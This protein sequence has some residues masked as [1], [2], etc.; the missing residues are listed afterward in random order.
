ML[1]NKVIE[2]I[3]PGCVVRIKSEKD[4]PAFDIV[5]SRSNFRDTY[6]TGVN[7]TTYYFSS[8]LKVISW[9]VPHKF[10]SKHQGHYIQVKT[11]PRI[12]YSFDY[13]DDIWH[14]VHNVDCDG[15]I[16]HARRVSCGIMYYH[17]IELE[18]IRAYSPIDP[19]L[20]EDLEDSPEKTSSQPM[21]SH[22]G[23][24]VIITDKNRESALK[25]I[26]VGTWVSYPFSCGWR[27]VKS[28]NVSAVFVTDHSPGIPWKDIT[29]VCEV[30]PTYREIGLDG[31]VY[32]V[33]PPTPISDRQWNSLKEGNWIKIAPEE[34][35]K[36]FL[37]R[38]N[39]QYFGIDYSKSARKIAIFGTWQKVIKKHQSKPSVGV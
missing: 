37:D 29:G 16:I 21:G 27:Q 14:K 15:P 10:T 18:D 7:Q 6:F 22:I 9:P 13:S 4:S 2:S 36:L 11:K 20:I 38:E 25:T 26:H 35:I 24:Q 17:R 28:L 8:I 33:K 1:S 31:K 3:V 23:T 12:N 19:E 39:G 32:G 30:D 34:Y 5:V